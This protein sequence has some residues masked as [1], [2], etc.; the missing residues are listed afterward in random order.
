MENHQKHGQ[1]T[2]I[3]FSTSRMERTVAL[4]KQYF[5]LIKY[6]EQLKQRFLQLLRVFFFLLSAVFILAAA[7][8][9]KVNEWHTFFFIAKPVDAL[10]PYPPIYVFPVNPRWSPGF[11][12]C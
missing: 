9:M 6:L 4:S 2:L 12:M 5:F 11:L 10:T 1:I 8:K 3:F 7:L